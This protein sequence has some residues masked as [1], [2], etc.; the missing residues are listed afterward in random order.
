MMVMDASAN[1]GNSGGPVCDMSGNI[2]G[3]VA[4]VT[5]R[6]AFN[7]SGAV[8]SADLVTFLKKYVPS[9]TATAVSTASLKSDEVSDRVANSTVRIWS[10][11]RPMHIP[12]PQDDKTDKKTHRQA[13]EDPWCMVC[14][15]CGTV[16]CSQCTRGRVDGTTIER[17]WDPISKTT[18]TIPHSARVTCKGCGGSGRVKC[19][20]CHG[21]GCD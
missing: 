2:C 10:L 21:S 13:L 3:V 20:H 4:V 1:P 14:Y 15:G 9:Y 17:N 6:Y 16:D 8:A 18:I 7:Y 19:P 11:C 5:L 12:L